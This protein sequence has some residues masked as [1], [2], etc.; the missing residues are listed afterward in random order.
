MSAHAFEPPS[1]QFPSPCSSVLGHQELLDRFRLTTIPQFSSYYNSSLWQIVLAQT[2]VSTTNLSDAAIAL[3]AA[4]HEREHRGFDTQRAAPV[5]FDMY[6]NAISESRQTLARLSEEHAVWTG[7]IISF[8]LAGVEALRGKP[9]NAS[10]HL[11]NGLKVAFSLECN[12]ISQ[13]PILRLD[14]N[15]I[16]ESTHFIMRLDIKLSDIL[17]GPE[18]V[19]QDPANPTKQSIKVAF[20]NLKNY[21]DHIMNLVDE[22]NDL[23]CNIQGMLAQLETW[24]AHLTQLVPA[25]F[26]TVLYEFQMVKLFRETICLLLLA[27]QC[28]CMRYT[29]GNPNCLRELKAYLSKLLFLEGQMRCDK[30][31][32]SHLTPAQLKFLAARHGLV[33]LKTSSDA[34]EPLSAPTSHRAVEELV[35]QEEGAIR[36]SGLAP[37]QAM[38]MDIT[39]ALENG[40]VSIRYCLV[41]Q[42]GSFVWVEKRALIWKAAVFRQATVKPSDFA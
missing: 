27:K 42:N 10:M 31:Y 25:A 28:L 32:V 5:A 7:F 34:S 37:P 12:T 40:S 23:S 11:T 2:S 33:S 36:N 38:C 24:D 18:N 6:I 30:K 16:E 8:M 20:Y 22:P 4:H 41:D 21:V 9:E 14:C 1:S 19:D 35:M 39:S 26:E 29:E 13:R 3:S 15:V 17:G